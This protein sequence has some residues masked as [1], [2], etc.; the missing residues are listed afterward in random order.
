MMKDGNDWIVDIDLKKLF[1]TANH[2]KLMSR[3]K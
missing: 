2:E 1:D 3:L